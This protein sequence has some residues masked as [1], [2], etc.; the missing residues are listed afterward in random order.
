MYVLQL[1]VKKPWYVNIPVG[2]STIRWQQIY[3]QKVLIRTFQFCVGFENYNWKHPMPSP[4]KK[5]KQKELSGKISK[6]E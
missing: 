3:S 2:I 6:K 4:C 5:T 1:M